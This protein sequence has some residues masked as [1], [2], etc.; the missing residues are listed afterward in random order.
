MGT[1]GA[2]EEREVGGVMVE[3]MLL[4]EIHLV[5]ESPQGGQCR[6]NTAEEVAENRVAEEVVEKGGEEV[7]EIRRR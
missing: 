1:G 7:V 2:T 4:E 3:G 5:A 6:Y